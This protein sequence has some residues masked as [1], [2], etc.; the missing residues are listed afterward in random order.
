LAHFL[1][2][3]SA[4]DFR[5]DSAQLLRTI[6]RIFWPIFSAQDFRGDSAQLLRTIWRIFWPIL[7]VVQKQDSE[8]DRHMTKL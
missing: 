4:Q 8:T 1:A 3:F 2:H 5:G 7:F 6:W